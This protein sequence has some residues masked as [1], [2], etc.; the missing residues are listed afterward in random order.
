[1]FDTI[2]KICDRLIRLIETRR[3]HDRQFFDSQVQPLFEHLLNIHEDYVAC[4]AEI[5]AVIDDFSVDPT[6]VR[7][8]IVEKRQGLR[9]IRQLVYDLNLVLMSFSYAKVPGTP[10]DPTSAKEAAFEFA[11][12]VFDYFRSSAGDPP[13]VGTWYT[14]LTGTV[15]LLIDGKIPRED[16]LRRARCVQEYV[17]ENW[18]KVT[19]RYAKLK[20]LCHHVA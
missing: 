11:L 17:P 20:A 1:M 15:E 19:L 7:E 14:G 6:S 4:I 12:A 5:V 10:D 18:S 2:A 9:H 8:T 3:L 13:R 16:C